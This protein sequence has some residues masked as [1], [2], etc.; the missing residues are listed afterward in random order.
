MTI[1]M[2]TSPAAGN[3]L[4]V[5]LQPPAGA[6]WWK[7]LRKLADDFT[8]PD[9]AEAE[10]VHSGTERVVTDAGGLMNGITYFYRAYYRVGAA[11][12]P[13]LSQSRSPS[14][15]YE[16]QTVDV[17]EFLQRR[18]SEGLA[19]EVSRGTL[20]HD[21]GSIP[22]YTA[23]PTYDN[24]RWPIVTIHLSDEA[25]DQRFVGEAIASDSWDQLA[26]AWD[27]P[28]GWLAR[29]QVNII[30]WSLNPDLRVAL[31]KCLRRIVIANLPVF[32]AHGFTEVNITV[33][34]IEDFENYAAPVYQAMCTFSCL[35]PVVVSSQAGVIEDVTQTIHD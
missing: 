6:S 24:V 30:G 1:A 5:F 31:R 32:D 15:S 3:A 12:Q 28:E 26:D 7:I 17:V 16:D 8:G 19:V 27:Q 21:D 29:V 4:T 18:L 20:R 2:I 9:D 34:D 23:P 11:W 22:V 25:P 10:V 14:A 35:A 33:Q 13:S